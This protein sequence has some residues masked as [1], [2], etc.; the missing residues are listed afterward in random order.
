VPDTTVIID[1]KLSQLVES[2]GLK[3][4]TVLFA[5]AVMVELEVLANAGRHS[6]F[7]G[8]REVEA[9]R[10]LGEDGRVKVEF[11]QEEVPCEP[12]IPMDALVRKVA[13]RENATL[14]T[15]DRVQSMVAG[16]VGCK[17]L[18]L[19]GEEEFP[20]LRLES[21]FTPDTMS[22]HL[23]EG[24][25]PIAK[26]GTV[27]QMELVEIS[28]E[29]LSENEI[30]EIAH[31]L[32]ERGRRDRHAFCEFELK[33]ATVL[34]LGDLRIA[35][36]EPPFSDG[37]EI[38]AVRPIVTLG[39]DDYRFSEEFKARLVEKRRGIMLAGSPGAGKSTFAQAIAE[40]LADMGFV[41]KTMESPRDL[42]VSKKIMQYAPMEGDMAKTADL[43]LL[44]RPDYTIYDELRKSSDFSVFA[45]MRMAGVGMI[46]VLHA[47]RAIDGIQRLIGRVEL[48]IIPQ[49]VDTVVFIDKGEVRQVYDVRFNVKVPYG[50]SESDLA[51]PVIEV[52]DFSSGDTEYE[53][54]TYGEQ[55]VVMPVGD[56][57]VT[58]AM[59][60]LA[61]QVIEK[62]IGR[63]V[64][65][66]VHARAVDG[67]NAIVFIEEK[68]IGRVVG[69]GG[70][71]I[72][73]LERRL[74]IHIDL[75]PMEEY[76]NDDRDKRGTRP[77]TKNRGSSDT[78]T[79]T[80]KP[81]D[82]GR[83][84]VTLLATE[85]VEEE[86]DEVV[87]CLEDYAS[88]EVEIYCRGKQLLSAT[89]S[90][91]GAIQVSVNTPYA[92][93]LLEAARGGEQLEFRF[94]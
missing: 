78:G 35:I 73:E 33:G 61:E 89:V 25:P 70:S 15:S 77:A 71:N 74:G 32:V 60:G 2:G 68:D 45:D 37:V 38:T 17:V 82:T 6:G 39:L 11:T 62:D 58:P 41:V 1:G 65:G 76:G 90:R 13:Q 72:K 8:L 23:K 24:T 86:D 5:E 20:P 48:G 28:S 87:L 3:D 55:I 34:Q 40:Y 29:P 44:V 63:M 79:D 9:L 84:V 22:V 16:A 26:R 21:Y 93:S 66:R 94:K 92:K 46:G 56:E 14:V 50:M 53:I 19:G 57:P 31:E 85:V 30:R 52:V 10:R 4:A 75:R 43:L 59:H 80:V 51:R 7:T 18:D 42:Q 27:M 64:R 54:Y 83:D 91:R 47:T 81:N 69:K 67:N 12:E 88:R 36:A 49:V